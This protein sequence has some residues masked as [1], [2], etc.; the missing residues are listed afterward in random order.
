MLHTWYRK[1]WDTTQDPAAT[2]DTVIFPGPV[3]LRG[4][5]LSERQRF[6]GEYYWPTDRLEQSVQEAQWPVLRSDQILPVEG[7]CACAP[8]KL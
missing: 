8:L 4:W 7:M 2:K 5:R 1:L 6:I 3:S